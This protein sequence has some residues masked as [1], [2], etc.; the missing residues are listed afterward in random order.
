M[1]FPRPPHPISAILILSF[2]PNTRD[3]ESAVYATTPPTARPSN[4]RRVISPPPGFLILILILILIFPASR[5][6][7]TVR[8][9]SPSPGTPGRRVAAETEGRGEGS[10]GSQ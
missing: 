4:F 6:S 1:S 9:S 10:G 5:Q 7:V 3:A 2:A 8:S